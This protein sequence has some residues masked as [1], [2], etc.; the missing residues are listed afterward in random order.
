[1]G[2]RIHK[3]IGYALTDIIYDTDNWTVENDGRFDPEGWMMLDCDEKEDRFTMAGF[4]EYIEAQLPCDKED[5]NHDLFDLVMV[6]HL[7]DAGEMKEVYNYIIYDMEYGDGNV[8]QLIPPGN[9]NWARY[10]DIIDYYDPVNKETD[11]GITDSVIPIDRA[12]WPYDT[13]INLKTMPPTPLTSIQHQLYNTVKY[14]G[15]E[16]Y[17]EV[18]Q[19]LGK[20]GLDTLEEFETHI[21]PIIPLGLIELLKYV[22]MFK[23]EKHIYELRPIIYGYWG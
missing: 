11:G 20:L 17:T 21:A 15:L 2:I 9:N 14:R 22:K 18:D 8:L 6:K 4:K 16:K 3:S 13:Y 23:D 1:M 5:Y 10:D 19:I 7:M 12:I